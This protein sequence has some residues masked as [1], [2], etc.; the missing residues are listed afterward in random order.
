MYV[1]QPT[2]P[3]KKK[4]QKI[5]KKDKSLKNK[6]DK[7]LILLSHNPFHSSLKSHKAE[8]VDG[9]KHWSS[10]VTGDIRIIWDFEEDNRIV[11]LLLDIGKH[12]GSH[13]VY[14]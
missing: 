9:N 8:T 7:T 12:S 3:F 10:W 11:I 6:Y 2:K 5:L 4:S 1:I 14:K 13:K